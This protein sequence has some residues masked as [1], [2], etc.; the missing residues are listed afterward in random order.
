MKSTSMKIS[1]VTLVNDSILYENCV[2][3]SL[4][5][6]DFVPIINAKSAAKGLNTGISR[7]LYDVIVLCHQ[8]VI[9]C[10]NWVDKLEQQMN[11]IN[12][13]GVLGTYGIDYEGR[14]GAGNA[15]SGTALLKHGTLPC[16][17]MSLDEHCLIVKK[18][19]G[20]RF[21]ESLRGFHMYGADL[22]LT[23]Y[24]HGLNCYAI[25]APLTH[26]HDSMGHDAAFEESVAWL[27]NKWRGKSRF[28]T[29]RTTCCFGKDLIQL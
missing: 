29:Y 12:D 25:D 11:M 26:L 5:V 14:D 16:R 13:F 27:T 24:A 10:K 18:S 1:V 17:A 3:N 9:F 19:C 6:A 7:T 4:R 8:D 20:L 28:K 22:C 15:I 21:D 23:A 2:L